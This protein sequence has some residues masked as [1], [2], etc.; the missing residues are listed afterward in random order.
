[1]PKKITRQLLISVVIAVGCAGVSFAKEP[2]IIKKRQAI[3]ILRGRS[4][5][6]CYQ[7]EEQVLITNGIMLNIYDEIERLKNAAEIFNSFRLDSCIDKDAGIPKYC[8]YYTG[9]DFELYLAFDHCGSCCHTFRKP[10]SLSN[11]SGITRRY[12]IKKIDS[13]LIVW[14][15]SRDE[16]VENAIAGI[17]E[18][19]LRE[20]KTKINDPQ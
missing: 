14:G 13:W 20:F 1:M 16:S 17:A 6:L 10:E 19:I 18:N 2:Q 8:I 15:D 7:S 4:L 5:K 3:E 11:S 12:I 9:K